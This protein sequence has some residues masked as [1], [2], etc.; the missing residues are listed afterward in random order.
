MM[1]C[2]LQVNYP[3]SCS[4]PERLSGKPWADVEQ[5]E[6]ACKPEIRYITKYF[7]LFFRILYYCLL[8]CRVPQSVVFS[9]P[10]ANVTLSCFIIGMPIPN[11]KWVLKVGQLKTV[12]ST[13]CGK[14]RIYVSIHTN[15]CVNKLS[16]FAVG[17][18]ERRK[19]LGGRVRHWFSRNFPSGNYR[20]NSA[21][22]EAQKLISKQKLK[23]GS[24]RGVGLPSGRKLISSSFPKMLKTVCFPGFENSLVFFFLVFVFSFPLSLISL[25]PSFMLEIKG[26]FFF[27]FSWNGGRG[28]S[29]AAAAAEVEEKRREERGTICFPYICIFVWG[30]GL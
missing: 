1:F 9:K 25:V 15:G 16:S 21:P 18:S 7:P 12:F 30:R 2:I 22:T 17:K 20:G 8:I 5:R 26:L 3:T 27:F 13:F 23:V 11:A 28:G 19:R 29:D 14:T 24:Q 10:G 6:F 4:E